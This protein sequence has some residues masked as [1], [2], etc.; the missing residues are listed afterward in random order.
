MPKQN[1]VRLWILSL[2][3]TRQ[4]GWMTKQQ[5]LYC[6]KKTFVS[7]AYYGQHLRA[8]QENFRISDWEVTIR[9]E[10][11]SHQDKLPW[12]ETLSRAERR[13][14]IVGNARS[15]QIVHFP[16]L[17]SKKS[18]RKEKQLF[19]LCRTDQHILT[20]G[21]RNMPGCHV[22]VTVLRA[23]EMV[24]KEATHMKNRWQESRNTKPV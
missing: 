6:P 16:I 8:C 12:Q 23:G 1:P 9:F 5:S 7:Y 14:P 3:L 21:V 24:R 19:P 18:V 20:L 11:E 2:L 4:V 15:T 17:V 22:I 13:L 10:Q